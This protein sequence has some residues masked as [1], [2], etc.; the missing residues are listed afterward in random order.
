M[1]AAAGVEEHS[2]CSVC[3][4]LDQASMCPLLS[5]MSKAE[6]P[7]CCVNASMPADGQDL[8]CQEMKPV[9]FDMHYG[10]LASNLQTFKRV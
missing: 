7:P 10:C 1:T 8:S 5:S 4:A 2:M 3:V 6:M 9:G